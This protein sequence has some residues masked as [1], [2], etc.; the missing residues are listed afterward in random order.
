MNMPRRGFIASTIGLAAASAATSQPD[1]TGAR[2]DFPWASSQTYL[3][4]ATEHP[5]GLHSSKAIEEY[6]HALSYGPDSARDKFENGYL[7]TEVKRM[8][9]ELIHAKPSEIG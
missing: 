9:A 1:L 7:M 3:N 4:T 6:L 2:A 8:F 5:L